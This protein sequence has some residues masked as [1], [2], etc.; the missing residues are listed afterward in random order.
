[1]NTDKIMMVHGSGGSATG[2]LINEIFAKAFD[3]DVLN[4]MED[5]AVVSGAKKIAMTKTTIPMTSTNCLERHLF[6]FNISSK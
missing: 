3:N 1:M 5:S 2:E 4:E 6:V